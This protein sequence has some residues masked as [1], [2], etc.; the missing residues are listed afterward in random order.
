MKG[1]QRVRAVLFRKC[2]LA[3]E[4]AGV[5]AKGPSPENRTCSLFHKET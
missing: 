2:R 4:S 3:Q 5:E 1:S